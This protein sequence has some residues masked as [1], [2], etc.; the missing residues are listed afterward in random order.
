MVLKDN[1]NLEQLLHIANILEERIALY[2]KRQLET[3][4][5]IKAMHRANIVPDPFRM[6]IMLE[7]GISYEINFIGKKALDN[8]IQKL[9]KETKAE[10]SELLKKEFFTHINQDKLVIKQINP[11]KERIL[12]LVDVVFSLDENFQ[13]KEIAKFI[14]QYSEQLVKSIFKEIAIFDQPFTKQVIDNLNSFLEA[15]N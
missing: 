5:A 4:R 1:N 10:L 12:P 15:K 9:N 11:S 8:L 13:R 7:A 3:K 14:L 6:Q 2:K